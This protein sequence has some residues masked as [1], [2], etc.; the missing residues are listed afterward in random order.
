MRLLQRG[1][2]VLFGVVLGVIGGLNEFFDGAI[3]L[4]PSISFAIVGV[5]LVFAALWA[6]YDLISERD[7]TISRLQKGL[8]G[9]ADPRYGPLSDLLGQST[10]SGAELS[11]AHALQA[12]DGWEEQTKKLIRAAYGEGEVAHIFTHELKGGRVFMGSEIFRAHMERPPPKAEVI[13]NVKGLLGRMPS[14]VIRSDFDPRGWEAF[15]A[16]AFRERHARQIR[17]IND[18]RWTCPWCSQ[19]H[20]YWTGTCEGCG[21]ERV[22]EFLYQGVSKRQGQTG[23]PPS[24][25]EAWLEKRIAAAELLESQRKARSDE[26]FFEAMGDWD[27]ENV[28]QM[29]DGPT[30]VAPDLVERYRENPETGQTDGLRVS[31]DGRSIADG[32]EECYYGQRLAWMRA[33]VNKLSSDDSP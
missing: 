29:H 12:L 17:K 27:V 33:T 18:P 4:A 20:A 3:K 14:L 16:T 22:G 8:A 2:V 32:E 21:A 15:D 1:Y 26:W 13:N 28:K 23:I 9:A 10:A 11:E 25:L 7:R 19:E 24:P 5:S 6:S 30:P 31:P